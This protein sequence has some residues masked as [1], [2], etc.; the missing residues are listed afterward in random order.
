MIGGQTLHMHT[1]STLALE[2]QPF[3]ADDFRLKVQLYLVSE[4]SFHGHLLQ[5]SIDLKTSLLQH[6][7]HLSF[8]TTEMRLGFLG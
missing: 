1:T 4:T 3:K 2:F 5:S 7:G 6:G 8:G